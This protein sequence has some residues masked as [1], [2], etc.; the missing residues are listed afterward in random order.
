MS[1]RNPGNTPP[2]GYGIKFIGGYRRE[3][4]PHGSGVAI[5]I[6]GGDNPY[7]MHEGEQLAAITNPS[8][9]RRSARSCCVYTH[10]TIYSQQ[11][12]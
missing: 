7:I 4:S 1:T 6:D 11:P 10:C 8:N 3:I 12:D 5:D 2:S 9:K